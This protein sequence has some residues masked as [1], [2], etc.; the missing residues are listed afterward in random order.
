MIM[1]ACAC[2]GIGEYVI[3]SSLVAG[4]GALLA[5]VRNT[6]ENENTET[7]ATE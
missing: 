7:E 1:L 2:G 6:D 3:V 5:L 4:C